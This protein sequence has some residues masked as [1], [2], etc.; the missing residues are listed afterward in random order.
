MTITD[1]NGCQI[2]ENFTII[3][4]T[5][6]AASVVST[7]E[8]NCTT[9]DVVQV[10]E[11]FITGGFPPHSISW[12]YGNVDISDPTIMRTSV[13]ENAVATITDSIGCTTSVIVPVDLLYLGDADF[14]MNSSF[15]TD[16]NLSL[17]HI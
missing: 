5:P 15:Y 11:L 14:S 1:A 6:L 4:Q 3:R 7:I 12:S 17:I 2:T 8:A 10:N 16:Y 13:N 9:K